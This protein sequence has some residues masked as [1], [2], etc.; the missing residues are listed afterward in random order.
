PA[1]LDNRPLTF[2]EFL[3]R[4]PQRIFMSATPKSWEISQTN[5]E[6]E[7]GI[8][9]QLI[10]PTGLVDPQII[11]KP[12][13]GQIDDLISEIEKRA[14]K[15]E[16]TLV[17]TLT[18]R[19]A[20]ELSTYLKDQGLNV[21]YLHSEIETLDRTDILEDLRLGKYDC[22]VGINLLREGLDL[23]EVSLVAILD[24]DKEGFLRSETS[25]VQTMGRAARHLEGMVILYADNIT[26][27]MQRAMDEIN[28]RRKTQLDYNKEHGITAKSIQKPIRK[29]LVEREEKPKEAWLYG[30]KEYQT[31][32]AELKHLDP[33]QLLPYDR[34]K[35]IKRLT[36]Q[37]KEAARDLNF[38]LA[39]QIRDKIK[40]I[41]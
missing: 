11:V 6:G 4:I 41:G 14:K 15:K 31:V 34:Q 39:A 23:P 3:R 37:M 7:N 18:K 2:E 5:G 1:A 38:E 8:V 21:H 40:E 22:L 13:K 27:S 24:A 28:R 9:E 32:L 35:L 10:R 26:G 36:R 30:D 17:T 16:R 29:K 20:E 25:L 12:T 33:S 19:M